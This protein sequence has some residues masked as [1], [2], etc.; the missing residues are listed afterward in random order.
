MAWNS[1]NGELLFEENDKYFNHILHFINTRFG[2]TSSYK[3][4]M[5]KSILDNLF[6]V[7]DDFVLDFNT[8]SKTFAKI[9]W[10]LVVKYKLPQIIPNSQF[11]KSKIEKI[12]DEMIQKNIKIDNIDY[13]VLN[14]ED[15]IKYENN[16]LKIIEK[17]VIG[18]LYSDLNCKIY[19]FDK[20]KK[21][22]WFNKDSYNFLVENKL[23]VEKINYYAWIL[24]MEISLSKHKLYCNNI[25]VKLDEST[26]RSTLTKF[27]IELLSK[28]DKLNCFYCDKIISKNNVHIDHFIPWKFA[29]DDKIWNLVISCS[30]CNISK[31]EKIP[32]AN[33][34]YKLIL[35]NAELLNESYEAKLKAL[36]EAALYNGLNE[37]ET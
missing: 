3:Y 10:N 11:N 25:G 37:W 26:K 29:K 22:I 21:I 27:K 4:G 12:I 16:V 6:N 36:R 28:G 31:K 30:K 15:K 2:K 23:V 33:Y 5:M 17:D 8:L 13:E 34:L 18:A 20:D 19:G 35:R 7:G 1:E 14:L 32:K 9:Y 24:W